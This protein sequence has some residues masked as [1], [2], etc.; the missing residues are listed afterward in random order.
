MNTAQ[1]H[2]AS[3]PHSVPATVRAPA[4]S[5]ALIATFAALIAVLAL[6]PGIGVGGV[7]VP[8]TLQTLGVM[9]AG[10]AL[11]ARRGA[12]ARLLSTVVGIGGVTTYAQIPVGT[13][14]VAVTSAV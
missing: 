7:A 2:D 12:L 13:C 4:G 3:T 14:V 1:P 8:I 6:T 9:L 5:L 10:G 11:D